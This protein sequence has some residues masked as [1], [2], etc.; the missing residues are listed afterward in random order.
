MRILSY[1]YSKLKD[2]VHEMREETPFTITIF[3]TPG[4]FLRKRTEDI[5]FK[6]QS[7][8]HYILLPR[9][10]DPSYLEMANSLI[11]FRKLGYTVVWDER[12]RL[13]KNN[14][15]YRHVFKNE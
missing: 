13:S 2:L 4:R 7:E 10:K 14:F 12:P 5:W 6:K 9:W 15:I 3:D 1:K 11:I 8:E